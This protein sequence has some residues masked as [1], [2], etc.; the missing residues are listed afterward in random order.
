VSN[1]AGF[2]LGP[3]LPETARGSL[4]VAPWFNLA[5]HFAS[6]LHQSLFP[7][8]DNVAIASL[9]CPHA[10]ATLAFP[11]HSD[12]RPLSAKQTSRATTRN[13]LRHVQIPTSCAHQSL[14]PVNECLHTTSPQ[15]FP[16]STAGVGIRPLALD[17]FWVRFEP[18]GAH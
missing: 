3:T 1:L 5:H 13:K 4:T 6:S 8:L 18:N 7:F 2:S 15:P 10:Q 14:D 17:L 9:F 16:F 12:R 11:L